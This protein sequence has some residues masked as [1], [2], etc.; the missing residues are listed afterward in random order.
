MTSVRPVPCPVGPSWPRLEAVCD[1]CPSGAV[2]CWAEP[3]P[4]G[5]RV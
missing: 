3:A 4:A 5:G 2:S 1:V